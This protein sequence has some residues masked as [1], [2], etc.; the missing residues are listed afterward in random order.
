MLTGTPTSV[1][2]CPRITDDSASFKLM[3]L[4]Y[5]RQEHTRIVVTREYNAFSKTYFVE[6]HSY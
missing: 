3:Y 5:N 6:N 4:L 2:V 1:P